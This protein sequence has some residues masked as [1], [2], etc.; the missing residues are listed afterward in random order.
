MQI[1]NQKIN[2]YNFLNDMYRD[3]YFP[4]E[5]VDKGKHILLTLCIKIERTK[6][7]APEEIYQLTHAATEQFNELAV[8]FENK[9]SEIETAA[10]DNI[11]TDVEFI[12]ES[13]GYSFDIEEA[14]APREW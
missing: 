9:G 7:S 8:E 11:A 14:I 13:Y 10:R 3:N 4:N 12:L 6:P 2:S 5:L 1:T